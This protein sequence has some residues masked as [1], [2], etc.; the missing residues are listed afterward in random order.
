MFGHI[1]A[2]E[3]EVINQQQQCVETRRQTAWL[4]AAEAEACMRPESARAAAARARSAANKHEQ[5]RAQASA[6]LESVL[7]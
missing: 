7:V 6:G 2:L 1:H 4:R 5:R 3:R